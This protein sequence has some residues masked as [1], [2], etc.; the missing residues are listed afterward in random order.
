MFSTSSDF[1]NPRYAQCSASSGTVALTG[2]DPNTKYYYKVRALGD[3]V[4]RVDSTWSVI[5][6]NATTKPATTS[7]ALLDEDSD[8]ENY[9]EDDDLDAFWDVLAKSVAK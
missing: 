1:A 6:N 2:L 5:V 8:F 4:S 7:S 3:N 9:F